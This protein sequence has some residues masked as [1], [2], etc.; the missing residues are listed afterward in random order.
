MEDAPTLNG[1]QVGWME[2]F[3]NMPTASCNTCRYPNQSE[4]YFT[5]DMKPKTWMHLAK[6]V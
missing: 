2:A 4:I 1:L 3:E 6:M 5:F